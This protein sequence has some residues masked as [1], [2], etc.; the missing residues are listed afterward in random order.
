MK[1]WGCKGVGGGW[2]YG[3]VGDAGVKGCE[4]GVR[5]GLCR[6]VSVG[7]GMRE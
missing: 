1:G 6:C 2:V 7:E 3:Y 4:S 5:G